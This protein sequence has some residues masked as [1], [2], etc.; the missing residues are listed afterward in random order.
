MKVDEVM[1]SQMYNNIKTGL[2]GGTSNSEVKDAGFAD[3]LESAL[4]EMRRTL[5][6]GEKASIDAMSGKGDVQ[7]LAEALTATEMALETA[8]TVR[9]RVVEAYQEILRMPI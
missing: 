5:Q 9:D 8:V 6:T 3:A 4:S 2:T 7:S 1:A